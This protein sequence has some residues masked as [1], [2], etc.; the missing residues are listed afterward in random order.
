[1]HTALAEQRFLNSFV[2]RAGDGAEFLSTLLSPR[3]VKNPSAV[4]VSKYKASILSE[5]AYSSAFSI[6]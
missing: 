6:S 3:L 1:M 2:P 4:T 5:A